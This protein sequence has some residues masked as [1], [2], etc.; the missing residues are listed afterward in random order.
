MKY[1]TEV[2]IERPRDQVIP[3][4]DS[5]ENLY[6]WQEG[7]QQM[8]LLEGEAGQEGAV[9][10]LVYETRRGRLEM[11]ETITRRKLPD[12]FS[13]V[14]RARGVHNEVQNFFTEKDGT[15]RWTMVNVFKFKGLMALLAPF[16]QGVFRSNTLLNME[17]FKNFAEEKERIS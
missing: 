6:K 7:L 10:K 9:S 2:T 14:Y 12:E 5:T 1:T 16:M 11:T 15:T 8:E 3:L 17:R 4:F 13:G